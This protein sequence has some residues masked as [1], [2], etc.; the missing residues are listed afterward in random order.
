MKQWMEI[1][2]EVNIV[3]KKKNDLPATVRKKLF[4][5]FFFLRRGEKLEEVSCDEN[6]HGVTFTQIQGFVPFCNG[7]VTVV[8]TGNRVHFYLLVYFLLFLFFSCSTVC[9][10]CCAL[11]RYTKAR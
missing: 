1:V 4:F 9:L 7:K 10:F 11:S 6:T 3:E 8:T 5:L 2:Q